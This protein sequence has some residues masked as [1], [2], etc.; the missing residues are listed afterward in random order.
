MRVVGDGLWCHPLRYACEPSQVKVFFV[1]LVADV[2]V[3]TVSHGSHYTLFM[4]FC[5][6]NP[7]P[8]DFG[9]KM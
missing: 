8:Y 6:K 1:D 4:S 9:V 5:V 2:H 7:P 3:F